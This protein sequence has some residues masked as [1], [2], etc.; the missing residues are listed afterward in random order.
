MM[1]KL[2][3]TLLILGGMFFA[4]CDD[5]HL[6]GSVKKSSDGKTYLVVA[7][8][9]GAQ[10]R[11]LKVDGKIWPHKLNE[12]GPIQPGDHTI[13]CGGKISFNIPAGVIFTF[14]Y[15]GP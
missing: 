1:M 15:W 10:C 7:D 3:A 12:Q 14:D 4:G 8:D 2:A 11:P 5:G 6:R 9:N 13:E